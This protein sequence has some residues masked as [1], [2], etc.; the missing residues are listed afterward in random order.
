MLKH[1][2]INGIKNIFA[3]TF[4]ESGNIIVSRAPGRVNLIGEHTD[5]NDGFVFPMALDFQILVAARKNDSETVRIYSSD[6]DQTVEF[7][8]KQ[9]IQYD[10]E[11]RWSNYLR[12]VL[13]MLQEKGVKLCGM[14]IA[15]QGNIPQGSGLSSSAALEVATVVM[16][17]KLLGFKIEKPE[18]V[19]L[20]QRAENKFVGMNCGI[21]DQFISMMGEQGHAL[22]LDCRSLD[23]KLVPL[24]LGDCRIII[25]QSGVKHTLVDSEYNKRRQE[26]EQG[27][28]ILARHFPAIK[29]LRDAKME[30]LEALK[31]EF[32]PV[33]YR[34]CKHVITEDDRV[35]ASMN[36]LSRGD[37]KSFG[38][39]MNASHDSLRDDYE[40]SCPEIDLLVRLA[41]EVRGVLGSRITGGGFGGCTV[42]LIEAKAEAEFSEHIRKNYQTTTGIIPQ[43]YISTAASGAAIIA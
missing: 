5:Y 10:Q 25:C 34:R 3:K 39:F 31:S 32:N 36:A 2:A 8:L 23:Y 28:A 30:Q 19:K 1:E 27:L 43:I 21:M 15:F 35:L 20:C 14:D 12:G 7:S 18:L 41:R 29:A 6:F 4:G 22:F 9:P 17:Q 33:V 37:L 40:V 26:C 13:V 42:S 11:K 16:A 38:Q 24:E